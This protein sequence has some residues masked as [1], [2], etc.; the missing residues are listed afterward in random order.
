[1]PDGIKTSVGERGNRLSGG[2]RKRVALAR[3]LVRPISVLI[4]DEA[5]SELDSETEQSI[6]QSVDKLADDLIILNI[7]HRRSVLRH[8]DRAIML[9]EGTAQEMNITE[10][11][12]SPDNRDKHIV[13]RKKTV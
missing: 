13:R 5:T 11:M 3:A 8:C 4:L 10:C 9:Q 12:A 2:E 7:S 1:M 6:F